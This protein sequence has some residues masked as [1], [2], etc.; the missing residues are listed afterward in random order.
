[1][2]KIIKVLI[3]FCLSFVFLSAVYSASCSN[4]EY[5][6][7]AWNNCADGSCESDWISNW[8]TWAVFLWNNVS[9]NT[10]EVEIRANVT[11]TGRCSQN[12]TWSLQD[13][14]LS[15]INGS[16]SVAFGYSRDV[17]KTQ[18]Q[19]TVSFNGIFGA[20]LSRAE[21]I[22]IPHEYTV[23]NDAS[24]KHFRITAWGDDS[25]NF[26][27]Y[28]WAF[29]PDESSFSINSSDDPVTM[30]WW[31][32][33][34]TFSP[35]DEY[36]NLIRPDDWNCDW[37]ESVDVELDLHYNNS[38]CTNQIDDSSCD[39]ADS[40]VRYRPRVAWLSD[41]YQLSIWDSENEEIVFTGDHTHS[42]WLDLRIYSYAPTHKAY[43]YA[44]WDIEILNID[45]E[46]TQSWISPSTWSIDDIWGWDIKKTKLWFLPVFTASSDYNNDAWIDGIPPLAPEYQQQDFTVN[47]WKILDG[48]DRSGLADSD[49]IHI[50][51]WPWWEPI[52]PMLHRGGTWDTSANFWEELISNRFNLNSQQS[53]N[54]KQR[55]LLESWRELT[56]DNNRGVISTH[57][58]HNHDRVGFIRRNSKI[59]GKDN[60]HDPDEEIVDTTLQ[61]P[62]TIEGMMSINRFDSVEDIIQDSPRTVWW[63]VSRSE[64]RNQVRRQVA[65]LTRGNDWWTSS[66]NNWDCTWNCF[67]NNGVNIYYREGD[68]T[69]DNDNW[70][71]NKNLVIADWGNVY[72]DDNIWVD[73]EENWILG[74]ISTR[75]L[76]DTDPFE[77]GNVFVDVD[78]TNVNSLIYADWGVMSYY[79]D[80]T[81][82]C[83]G[84]TA[85]CWYYLDHKKLRHQ[86]Y[87]RWVLWTF[88]TLWWSNLAWDERQ[89]PHFV[90]D[91]DCDDF[92]IQR[93]FDIE[94]IRNFD[95]IS[96]DTHPG[97]GGWS[98]SPWNYWIPYAYKPD[99]ANTKHSKL[100][101]WWTCD[102]SDASWWRV[103]CDSFDVDLRSF[104]DDIL[105][106]SF[107]KSNM[108]NESITI[109]DKL[110]PLYL[111]HDSRISQLD[112]PVFGSI[113][114]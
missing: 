88:N 31:Y 86:L 109:L 56:D 112:L 19:S 61:S 12:F 106:T 101:W 27:I 68:I 93:S 55:F 7:K 38:V 37:C 64:L 71:N 18:H 103:V 98:W 62:I 79:K 57:F 25:A 40:A 75:D 100:A 23:S 89:C 70:L 49:R 14:A 8:W 43:E 51:Y 91:S 102:R 105:S 104:D 21:L 111:K 11:W 41:R 13:G 10:F 63:G 73:D 22:D 1:M 99:P 9:R 94:Y 96:A 26:F 24:A 33:Y 114:E 81:S 78:V 107:H 39:S 83:S 77:S 80:W 58:R 44:T 17:G 113:Y 48:W 3:L 87:I 6:L 72:I 69:I 66:I 74:I 32:H 92:R 4:F 97:A 15:Q 16:D 67:E 45:Y 34:V 36:K 85:N 60:Y 84:D 29:D 110:S 50:R 54:F 59:V 30:S 28:P 90:S 95:L 47:V 42:D 52:K 5:K 2:K 65:I 46:V 20:S 108:S 53:I 76:S 82:D 35:K